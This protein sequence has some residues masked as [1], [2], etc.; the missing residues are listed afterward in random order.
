MRHR[1]SCLCTKHIIRD[2]LSL[3]P[4]IH[5]LMQYFGYFLFNKGYY[6]LNFVCICLFIYLLVCFFIYYL[7]LLEQLQS[8][9]RLILSLSGTALFQDLNGEW[10]FADLH[11]VSF[12]KITT[13]TWF[14]FCFQVWFWLKILNFR[15]LVFG[16]FRNRH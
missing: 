15:I 6:Y 11:F 10:I 14:F 1:S 2:N 5:I 16:I 9:N 12:L 3:V 4:W 8:L 13:F 7:W